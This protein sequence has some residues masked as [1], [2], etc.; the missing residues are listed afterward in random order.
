MMR[1]HPRS[2]KTMVL[3]EEAHEPVEDVMEEGA[4]EEL[5]G[6]GVEFEE[7]PE[8]EPL[9]GGMGWL[10]ECLVWGQTW[11]EDVEAVL[12]V[13]RGESSRS[14]AM[15][16]GVC[17]R[18]VLRIAARVRTLRRD[19]EAEWPELFSATESTEEAA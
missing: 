9:T 10:D 14:V 7:E 17:D 16:C 15:S 18:W 1:E 19:A 2:R 12:K 5:V 3:P 11:G 4:A 8:P 6:P 13:L